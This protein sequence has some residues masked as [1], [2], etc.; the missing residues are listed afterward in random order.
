MVD[1]FSKSK[2]ASPEAFLNY[3]NA[4]RQRQVAMNQWKDEMGLKKDALEMDRARLASQLESQ[5]ILNEG[6]RLQLEITR[7]YAGPQAELHLLSE[8]EN[9]RRRQQRH[10]SRP[11]RRYGL[12]IPARGRLRRNDRVK[13]VFGIQLLDDSN[14]G[15]GRVVQQRGF[16]RSTLILLTHLWF[17]DSQ[18]N[19]NRSLLETHLSL[20]HN[21]SRG[22]RLF[23]TLY[24]LSNYIIT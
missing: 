15:L 14:R 11:R 20:L 21:G 2:L 8:S 19:Q 22:S 18:R 23:I 3:A 7:K 4:E 17:A 10:P 24:D 12:D 6:Q 1:P 5:G 9:K 13:Q 16:P